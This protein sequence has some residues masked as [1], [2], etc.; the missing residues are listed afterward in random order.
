M[1]NGQREKALKR[2][3][4]AGMKGQWDVQAHEDKHSTGI[5][6]LSY[7]MNNVNGW[8]ELKQIERYPVT[9]SKLRHF[10]AAQKRW[11]KNR[12]TKGGNCFLL[13]QVENDYYIVPWWWLDKL[14]I[15]LAETADWND[16][17][18]CRLW[19]EKIN[20]KELRKILSRRD[21]QSPDQTDPESNNTE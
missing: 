9:A 21:L 10:T 12:G 13:L 17:I 3:I 6:D 8:V 2:Y 4:F 20:F 19:C 15:K 1:A 5:P 18:S 14:I 16:T 11:L 7:G